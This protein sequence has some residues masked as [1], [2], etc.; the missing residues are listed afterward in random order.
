MASPEF[1]LLA[2]IGGTN[3]R[4]ALQAK[5][6]AP[7][8]VDVT[9]CAEFGSL[10]DAVESYLGKAHPDAPL[11]RAAFAIASP[12]AGDQ[13]KM[14]NHP[15]RFSVSGVRARLRLQELRVVNDFAA[16]ALAVPTLGSGDLRHIG[17]GRA[18]AGAPVA[19]IGPGTGLGVSILV[20][21]PAGPI[22][23]ATEGGHATLAVAD[24]REAQVV[25]WL[26]ER[27]D[28]ASAE[29]ALS[30]PGLVNLYAA[31]MDIDGRAAPMPAPDEVTARAVG[32]SDAL[33]AEAVAM[34]CAMLGTVA[35]NLALTVGARGGI[36]I[37]G[38]IVPALGTAFALSPFR[39]RFEDKGRFRPYVAAIPTAVIAREVPA[40]AGLAALLD[41]T[42]TAI[43]G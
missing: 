24:D 18:V 17:G 19:V 29:R 12:V 25:A 43:S 27:F 37:A 8:K 2:D 32:G 9:R 38:G 5:D 3:A 39:S 31:L 21:G 28:H 34:F 4:F 1:R 14:V 6:A 11:R 10:E 26:R 33:A 16:I 22:A 41:G 30:G 35:G 42:G 20:H 36:Y 40:F 7:I 15:W 23:I 13:V